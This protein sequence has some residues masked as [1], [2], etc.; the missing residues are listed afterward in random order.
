M[1]FK[2]SIKVSQLF[3]NNYCSEC[4]KLTFNVKFKFL[5]YVMAMTAFVEAVTRTTYVLHKNV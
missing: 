4:V 2:E 5:E 1:Y 3:C